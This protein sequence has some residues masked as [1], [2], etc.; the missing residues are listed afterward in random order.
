MLNT[1]REA[2]C[3][4]RCTKQ[5][6]ESSCPHTNHYGCPM[7][8]CNECAMLSTHLYPLSLQQIKIVHQLKS[9]LDLHCSPQGQFTS[10]A[11]NSFS[12]C[13][14]HRSNAFQHCRQAVQL[15]WKLWLSRQQNIQILRCRLVLSWPFPLFGRCDGGSVTESICLAPPSSSWK[16]WFANI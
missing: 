3:S 14:W 13:P 12:N 9:H 16:D 8:L 6:I 15:I 11:W 2:I 4:P 5:W 10:T 1:N 7:L